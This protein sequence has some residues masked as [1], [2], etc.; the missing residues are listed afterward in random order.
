MLQHPNR[1]P[2]CPS[3]RSRGRADTPTIEA[4]FALGP[5]SS[6]RYKRA[7]EMYR[8][9]GKPLKEVDAHGFGCLSEDGYSGLGLG[10]L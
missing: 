10:V 8:S 9:R 5:F 6:E 1:E 2:P 4:E 7:C 3:T